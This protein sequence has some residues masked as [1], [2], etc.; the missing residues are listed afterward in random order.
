MSLHPILEVE[1]FHVWG[2]N[3]KGPFP[4]SFGN[5]YTSLAIVYM[6][7]WIEAIATSINGVKIVIQILKKKI[8]LPAMVLHSVKV[9]RKKYIL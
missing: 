2:I 1:I 4:P 7:K 5:I 8:F 6:S 9:V 3:F